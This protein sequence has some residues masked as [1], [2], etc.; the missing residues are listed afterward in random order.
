MTAVLDAE[1]EILEFE[2]GEEYNPN[3]VR[4]Y[5]DGT[6][7]PH[8][9]MRRT[10]MTPSAKMLFARLMRYANV[11]TGI[12]WPSRDQLARD[13]GMGSATIGRALVDLHDMGLLESFQRPGLRRRGN[14]YRFLWSDIIETPKARTRPASLSLDGASLPPVSANMQRESDF[15][16]AV[17]K[18]RNDQ[19]AEPIPIIPI[20]TTYTTHASKYLTTSGQAPAEP[21][22]Q[23]PRPP[24]EPAGKKTK[25][26]RWDDSSGDADGPVIGQSNSRKAAEPT[27]PSTGSIANGGRLAVYFRTECSKKFLRLA[28]AE[29]SRRNMSCLGAELKRWMVTGE[30]TAEEILAMVDIWCS[31]ARMKPGIPLW[32]GFLASRSRVWERAVKLADERKPPEE[33]YGKTY[34]ASYMN[35][36]GT[37]D[38]DKYY[39]QFDKTIRTKTRS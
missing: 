19:F 30:A 2:V 26:Q 29:F 23:S 18:G 16:I 38:P 12:A 27:A 34:L 35:P 3:L 22:R 37:I 36:D 14:G 25:M 28:P 5:K 24:A 13:L 15:E 9:L 8:W 32:K 1:N 39:A 11:D 20:A 31:E 10:D 21:V 33:R 17:Q 7:I 6:L 4:D